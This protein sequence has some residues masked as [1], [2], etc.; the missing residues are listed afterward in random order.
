MDSRSR[1]PLLDKESHL[2][3]ACKAT[4]LA[5]SSFEKI[6]TSPS[7]SNGSV[8]PKVVCRCIEPKEEAAYL[9]FARAAW[10]NNSVQADQSFLAWLYKE[11]PNTRGIERD[12]LVLVD[13]NKIVGAFHRMRIP[14][15]IDSKRLIVPSVHDLFVRSSHRTVRGEQCLAPPGMHVMLA[16]LEKETHVALFGLGEVADKIYGRMRNPT[17]PVFWL[18]KFRSRAKAGMQMVASRLGR[19]VRIDRQINRR[20]TKASD[21]EVSRIV[22]P[23]PDELVEALTIT[24]AAPT[25]PD[26]DLASYRWRFFHELGPRNILL[27]ARRNRTL[28]GRAVVSVGLKNGVSV[29]RV[30]ELVFQDTECLGALLH[31]IEETFKDM[32]VPVCLAVTSSPEVAER[33]RRAGWDF[34]KKAIG[35]RW[36]TQRGEIRPEGFWICGGAWDYG[37][38]ARIANLR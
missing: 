27:L 2:K 34:R 22:D 31:E 38:D 9:E 35:A 12:L 37:C 33:L 15:R 17:V 21:F 25:Y 13:G 24:P 16:A 1:K 19:P 18:E 32:R 5:T 4:V 23:A 36:F 10:G 3:P 8:T 26:W 30:V 7:L 6:M 28:S 11:N 14:W 29:A 20:I